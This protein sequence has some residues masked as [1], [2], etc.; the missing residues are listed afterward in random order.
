MSLKFQYWGIIV[1][2]NPNKSQ[3]GYIAQMCS[4]NVHGDTAASDRS[5]VTIY[6]KSRGSDVSPILG[7]KW[8]KIP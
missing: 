7:Q 8:E 2:A 5:P 6:Y 4:S 3:M 1:L